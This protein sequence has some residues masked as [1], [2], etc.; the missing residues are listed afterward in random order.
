MSVA[1]NYQDKAGG[2]QIRH[3]SACPVA[4]SGSYSVAFHWVLQVG[5]IG[6][7]LTFDHAHWER[8]RQV[9]EAARFPTRVP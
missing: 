5:K 9:E 4:T 6:F 1:V 3:R 8:L 7:K 2:P